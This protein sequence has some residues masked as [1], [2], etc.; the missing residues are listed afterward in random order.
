MGVASG[1]DGLQTLS[2]YGTVTGARGVL[3][4]MTWTGYL[5]LETARPPKLDQFFFDVRA[6]RVTQISIAAPWSVGGTT[7]LAF[8]RKVYKIA[9]LQT[10]FC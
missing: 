2:P 3:D 4:L 8:H 7:D 9:A 6:S 1:L 5:L 10:V